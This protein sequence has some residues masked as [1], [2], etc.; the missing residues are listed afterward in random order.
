MPGR[1]RKPPDF[2]EKA[3]RGDRRAVVCLVFIR[4]VLIVVCAAIWWWA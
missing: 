4:A 2:A 1:G 3:E